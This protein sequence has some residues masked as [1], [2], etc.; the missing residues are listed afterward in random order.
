MAGK[1][2][3]EIGFL[4]KIAIFI[5]KKAGFEVNLSKRV[6]LIPAVDSKDA[7]AIGKLEAN[8]AKLKAELSKSMKKEEPSKKNE[9]PYPV[10]IFTSEH[11]LPKGKIKILQ[12]IDGQIGSSLRN[13]YIDYSSNTEKV[14]FVFM[15]G[16]EVKYVGGYS[17]RD[18]IS[19]DSFDNRQAILRVRFTKNGKY[20]PKEYS[21]V[22]PVPDINKNSEQSQAVSLIKT[23]TS[24]LGQNAELK[25][26][27][28][29][30]LPIALNN[31]KK[32]Y[33]SLLQNSMSDLQKQQAEIERLKKEYLSVKELLSQ[34]VSKN[35]EMSTELSNIHE[36][37]ERE[38]NEMKKVKNNG[39]TPSK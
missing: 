31:M 24:L 15:V 32:E 26:T 20:I 1:N 14:W 7:Q 9:L 21:R 27:V 6:L 19:S 18:S 17:L 34:S 38:F 29:Q 3:K 12:G 13:I 35:K 36:E 37:A 33:S 30:D 8:N 11:E 10:S 2:Q 23:I 39:S 25:R 16:K 5:A 4:Q 28:S 22:D